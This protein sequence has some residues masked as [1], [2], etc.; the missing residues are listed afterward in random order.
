[1]AEELKKYTQW[2]FGWV[3][4]GMFALY[5]WSF[6]PLGKDDTDPDGIGNRSGFTLYT[7]SLTGCQY[8]RPK[9]ADTFNPRV[10][11]DG[12]SHEGCKKKDQ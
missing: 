6:L 4:T 3:M 1:M 11:A 2:L 5:L 8:L 10:S 12:W 7:D 9:A